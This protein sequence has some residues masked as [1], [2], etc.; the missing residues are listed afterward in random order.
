MILN[1]RGRKIRCY[2]KHGNVKH[3]Q[4]IYECLTDTHLD[5]LAQESKEHEQANPSTD[6][7]R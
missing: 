6:A 5:V 1:I 7:V 3:Y 4:R 2:A